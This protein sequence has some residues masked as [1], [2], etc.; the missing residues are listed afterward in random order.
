MIR[1]SMILPALLSVVFSSVAVA[2]DGAKASSKYQALKCPVAPAQ[3]TWAVLDRDGANRPVERYLSSLGGGETGTG[4]IT[5]PAFRIASDTISFT[6]CGHDGPKGGQKKNYIAL[7]DARK[8]TVLRQ[9]MAPGSDPMQA[10]SWDVAPLRGREVR[11]EVRDGDSGTAFAWMGIGRIDAGEAL[12]VDFRNGMP[13]G[14][15]TTTQPVEPRMEMVEGGIP[16]FRSATTYTLVPAAGALEIPCGF[17]AERLFIL[18]GTI[19]VGKPL[20]TYGQIEIVYKSGSPDRIPLMYGYTL[21]LASKSLSRSK[22]MY[23]H[24]SGDVFQHYL[25]VAPRPA[26]IEK[27]VLRRNPEQ[28]GLPQI[29]AITCQTTAAS[30]HLSALPDA[31]LDPQEAAWIKSHTITPASP[32]LEEIRAEIRR[33]HKLP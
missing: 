26:V 2:A 15:N 9:T 25:V 28:D 27:I 23:L 22:A 12:K 31:P 4:A 5:S 16:F 11:I 20:E 14:W 10:K 21:D 18:G 7:V 29:T 32:N 30:E 17:A 19:P 13:E 24:E 1:N 6:I 3:G 33:A 8:G